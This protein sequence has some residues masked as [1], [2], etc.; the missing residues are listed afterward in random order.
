MKKSVFGV[1]GGLVAMASVGFIMTT[2]SPTQAASLQNEVLS[3]SKDVYKSEKDRV[4]KTIDT[5]K[6]QGY[7][8][9]DVYG[10]AWEGTL[11]KDEWWD[12][13]VYETDMDAETMFYKFSFKAPWNYVY[14]EDIVTWF[15][16]L[17]G[18]YIKM[19]I[20]KNGNWL[21]EAYGYVNNNRITREAETVE[22]IPTSA[23]KE[24]SGGNYVPM[25]GDNKVTVQYNNKT[26]TLYN[27][28]KVD[29]K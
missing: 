9:M 2:T 4:F 18:K 10:V 26:F 6:K 11:N 7:Y 20:L 19:K 27:D 5:A 22:P 14:Y 13:E 3:S 28:G 21:T 25:N 29:V 15:P 1:I 23:P 12:V 16:E 24:A 8:E 17:K